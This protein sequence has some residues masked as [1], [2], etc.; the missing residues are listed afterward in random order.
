MQS[1]TLVCGI[2]LCVLP[3][4]SFNVLKSSQESIFNIAIFYYLRTFL[5]EIGIK[6]NCDGKKL[7]QLVATAE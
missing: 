6:K 4:L 5:S 2:V 1:C 3:T 7:G